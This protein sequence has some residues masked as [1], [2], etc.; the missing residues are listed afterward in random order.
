MNKATR[1][2]TEDTR[3]LTVEQA[4]A[5]TGRGRNTCRDW[6]NEIGATRHYGRMVRYDKKIIDAALDADAAQEE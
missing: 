6:C 2:S 4:M 3:M 1:F 5:Y